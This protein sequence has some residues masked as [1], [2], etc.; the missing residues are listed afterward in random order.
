MAES[1]SINC[2]TEFKSIRVILA[3]DFGKPFTEDGSS[4]ALKALTPL[5]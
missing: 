2:Q 1:Q 3:Y 5:V 4:Y